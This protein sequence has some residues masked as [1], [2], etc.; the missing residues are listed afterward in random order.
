MTQTDF[1]YKFIET[2]FN[3]TNNPA[4]D[5]QARNM[6]PV[7]GGNAA[8]N[9]PAN[10]L[11]A[12][13]YRH[14]KSPAQGRIIKIEKIYNPTIFD[15]FTGELKRTLKKY[16]QCSV[17]DLT[18]LLFHGSNNTKP[19]DI[20]TSDYGLDMRFANAGLYGTGIYFANNSHYS[21]HYEHSTQ[22][23][24]GSDGSHH[25]QARQMFFCFVLTG[26]VVSL[27]QQRLQVPPLKS[28]YQNEL[29][30]SN[31]QFKADGVAERFDSVANE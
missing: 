30:F 15:K 5:K 12:G 11:G 23:V 22:N 14:P 9:A 29:K 28:E 21:R 8:N 7:F 3:D 18:K 1:E 27:R 13:A 10:L 17:W 31:L 4:L 16:P 19:S 6:G 26:E 20:Y 25:P 2:A 24:R